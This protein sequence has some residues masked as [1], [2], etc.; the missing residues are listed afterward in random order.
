[1]SGAEGL[2]FVF[3]TIMSVLDRVYD[4]DLPGVSIVVHTL[5]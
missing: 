3:V 1:M 4:L 2:Y 5:I